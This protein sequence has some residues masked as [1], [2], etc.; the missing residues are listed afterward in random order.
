MESMQL[1]LENVV[2][3]VFDGS[4]E[5]GGGS[6]EVHLALCRIF[7]GLLATSCI[8]LEFFRFLF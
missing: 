8:L 2:N 4:N 7:E 6:S 5:F 1:A 3:A